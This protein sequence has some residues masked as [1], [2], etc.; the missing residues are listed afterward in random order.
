[1]WLNAQSSQSREVK[2]KEKEKNGAQIEERRTNEKSY[3]CAE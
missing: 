2:E 1:L 3:R